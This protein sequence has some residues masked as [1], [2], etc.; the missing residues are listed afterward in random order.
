LIHSSEMGKKKNSKGNW[1]KVWG[2][3][4]INGPGSRAK[5]DDLMRTGKGELCP[6]IALIFGR[7]EKSKKSKEDPQKEV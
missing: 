1:T 6:L 3:G 4:G 2:W 5:L 7:R